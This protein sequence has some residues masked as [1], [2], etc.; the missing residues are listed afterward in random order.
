M[1]KIFDERELMKSIKVTIKVVET[2]KHK[3]LKKVGLWIAKVG[4]RVYGVGEVRV[5]TFNPRVQGG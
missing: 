2:P 3:L 5:E 4:F 1:A